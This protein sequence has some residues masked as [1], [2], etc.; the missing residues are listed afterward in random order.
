MVTNDP[1]DRTA[2][3]KPHA[4]RGRITV[5]TRT[6]IWLGVVVVL[7]LP[8]GLVI[9]FVTHNA[10]ARMVAV[11]AIA[12][13]A[14]LGILIL[15]HTVSAYRPFDSGEMRMAIAGSFVIVYFV[16]L[17]IFLFSI[18]Q[19]TQFAQDYVR[20]LTSLLGVIVAFYFAS[21][22][23]VQYAKIRAGAGSTTPEERDPSGSGGR[24][25]SPSAGRD[26]SPSVHASQTGSSSEEL[27]D[28]IR[29]L[30]E[31]VAG[32]QAS[33]ERLMAAAAERLTAVAAERLTAAVAASGEADEAP[34]HGGPGSDPTDGAGASARSGS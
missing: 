31:S 11:F 22:A 26:A 30:H 32:L 21:S 17:A 34:A 19:P 1:G 10:A 27:R 4:R 29:G 28:Q 18:H 33:M 16:V 13:V 8:A 20:N 14:F 12:V 23:A 7:A 6:A 15:A 24:E 2:E 9:G 3:P 5:A 25:A